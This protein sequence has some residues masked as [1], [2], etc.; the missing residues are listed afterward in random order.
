[1][2]T[3]VRLSVLLIVGLSLALN[4]G[5]ED[6]THSS[7]YNTTSSDYS[8]TVVVAI[9]NYASG[10]EMNYGFA[11]IYVGGAYQETVLSG[12]S[13]RVYLDLFNNEEVPIKIVLYAR[14]G[15]IVEW[16]DFFDNDRPEYHVNIYDDRV[17][18]THGY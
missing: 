2:K 10:F 4:V 3:L 6:N 17:N 14:D 8:Q 12:Y 15:Q 13:T 7:G 1:M 5:C 18:T 11:E 16:V 9:N